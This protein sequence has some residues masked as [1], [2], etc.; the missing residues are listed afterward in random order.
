MKNQRTSQMH[1]RFIML[2][3]FLPADQQPP[4]AIHPTVRAFDYPAARRMLLLAIDWL[5]VLSTSLQMQD[6]ISGQYPGDHVRKIIAFIQAQMMNAVDQLFRPLNDNAIERFQSDR[7]VIC[8][9]SCHHYGKRRAALVTQQ[10]PFG[11]LFAAI[12]R[13]WPGRCPA[14]RGFGDS[15]VEGLPLPLDAKLFIIVVE[16]DLP[17]ALEETGFDPLAEDAVNGRRRRIGLA[18]QRLPLTAGLGQIDHSFEDNAKGSRRSATRAGRF[19][20][21]K[22]RRDETPQII[23]NMPDCFYR[24]LGR[25]SFPPTENSSKESLSCQDLFRHFSYRLLVVIGI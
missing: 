16:Q 18:R 12:N 8:I 9:G 6:V 22:N 20:W 14:Q 10:R 13:T 21:P 11:S 24:G 17:G 15:P 23:R 5:V 7:L 4:K 19:L 2:N 1:H 25:Q 3:L